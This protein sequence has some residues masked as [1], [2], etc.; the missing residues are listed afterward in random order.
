MTTT[1]K[2]LSVLFVAIAN[3]LLAGCGGGGSNVRAVPESAPP[4][5][6]PPPS[7]A[8]AEP[9]PSPVTA[10]CMADVPSSAGNQD[11][12]GGRSSDHALIKRGEG[13]LTLASHSSNDDLP[14]TVDFRFGG[15]TTIENGG[16]RVWSN[17]T[18]HSNVVVQTTG[19]LQSFGTITGSLDNHGYTL[20][21]DKV[22]GDVAN[23]G[24]LQPGSS[25]YGDVI[26]ARVEGNLRQTPNGT[27]I[28]VIGV[29]ASLGKL[30]GGFLMVTGRADIDGTLRLAQYGDEFGP[31]PLPGAPLS[32]QVLHADGGVFGQFAKW[33]S[34]G[35]FVT[36]APRYLS[37]DVYFDITAISAAQAMAAAPV[38]KVDALTL[39]SAVHF[40][41]ALD[42]AGTWANR[43]GASLTTTQRQFLA[44]V[45][46]VQHLQDYGQATR[47]L[48]SLSGQGYAAA[49]DALLRQAS[50]PN[51]DLMAR[52]DSL[53]T[54]SRLGA[55][56]GQSTMLASGSGAFND[57]RAGFDQWLGER[58]LFGSSFAWSD[59]S[60]RFDRSGG[61]ARDQ[62]PQWDVY[63]QRLGRDD[64]YLFG[65]IGYSRHELRADRQIDLGIGQ[66]SV[67]ARQDL[68]LLRS[69]FE[70]GR[71]FHIGGGRLTLFGAVSH[72]M[73]H[74][75]G[76]IEQGATGFE[77][78]VQPSTY[79]RASATAGLRIGQDWHTNSGRWM[80]VNL[81]AG[82]LQTL[83][84]RDDA[85]AA[86]TGTPDVRF[87]LDGMQQ[88]RN[89]GWLHLN[90]GTGNEH[91][92]W[93]LSYDRQASDEAL[94]L[95][96]KLGF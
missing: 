32:L 65:D 14:P 15:G 10:D 40:D 23:D 25:I 24:V 84:D 56:S 29:D 27:L 87:A 7:S 59:G 42:N 72:V 86:F 62:S 89:T 81:A 1:T 6:P 66:R 71:N 51:A 19:T 77:L 50:L 78:A 16:L 79:Q 2:T 91:W 4:D 67:R 92:N 18:L 9:C 8:P 26:P 3:C 28:A 41:A 34:P 39:R 63:M 74:G 31:Y 60:L 61:V 35:L 93:L 95:G 46:A 47:T 38:V 33:T 13:Q 43:P 36:G 96:A 37:N 53:H 90:L 20:M 80:S 75:A 64:T 82:Y 21:W 85:Q 17:A 12:T 73:L 45:G 49:T 30:T 11:M 57:Q 44:S 55:W 76:F 70:A 22:V 52:M 54:G 88:G 94:S 5:P 58:T 48:D 69:Y 68:D 83:R